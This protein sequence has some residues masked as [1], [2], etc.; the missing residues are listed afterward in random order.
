MLCDTCLGVFHFRRNELGPFGKTR[1]LDTQNSAPHISFHWLSFGHH[2]TS[3]T[4]EQSAIAG[5]YVCEK[6]WHELSRVQ[7]S[8]IQ[9]EKTARV[10]ET[11]LAHNDQTDALARDDFCSFAS[12]NLPQQRQHSIGN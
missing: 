12:L 9:K 4:L 2:R 5:C 6:T 11:G 1:R 3:L 10:A 8:H 7:K